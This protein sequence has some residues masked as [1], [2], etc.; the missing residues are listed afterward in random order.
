MPSTA[1]IQRIV[2]VL[3]ALL[4]FAPAVRAQAA[5]QES[6]T[7]SFKVG[8]AERRAIL[9]N[10]PKAGE[11]RPV[12]IILH[13][14]MGS[15]DDMRARSGFDGVAKANGFMAVY[16]EGTAF[17]AIEGRHAWNTGHLLRRQVREAD[18]I[19]Y[20]DGL[21]D[22]LIA[23]HGADPARMFMTGGS[24]G[25]MM[26]FV[27][28][29]TRPERLA[30]AAPVVASMFSFD[31]VPK[32]P[33]PILIINGAKDEEV[34]LAGGLSGNAL[35]RA[36]QATPFKPVREVVDFWVKANRSTS[37]GAVR[38]DGSVTT[39]TYAAGESGAVTESVVDRDG[40]HGWPGAPSRRDGNAPIMAFQ[41]A[42]RVW[43]FFAGKS[44]ATLEPAVK[45]A[46]ATEVIEFPNLVDAARN[47]RVPI[48]V[49]APSTGGPHP[50]IVL[51]HGAGGDWDTHF[52]QAQDL[53]ANGY[54][55]LCLEHVGSNRERLTKGLRPMKNLDAMIRDADEVLAR[56]KDVS[57]AIDQATA[58]NRSHEQLRGR[59]DLAKVGAMG[60]SFGA[61]TT[62][63]VCGMR[64]ALD[65]LEPP[66]APGKGLGPDLRDPRIRC[67][68]ALS[69]QGV[70]EPFFVRDSF[71]TLRV[72]LLGIS[73]T[74]DSQQAGQPA[75]NRK[76]AFALW[77]RG[78]HRF[79]WLE[80]ARHLDF[81]DS[82]GSGARA[83]PSATRAD[84]QPVTRAAALAFFDL[85]LKSRQDAADRLTVERL[86][87]L[88][89]GAI[90]K[91]EVLV[92]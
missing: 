31:V 70:G 7:V 15:A 41:G 72:P 75:E 57:F 83:L 59:L 40:G 23:D 4:A 82:S 74:K 39:T 10:A 81:T 45:A 89:Q 35:V 64:P 14:G 6:E 85:H 8:D 26:T 71:A 25:G 88:L 24:N 90:R 12:V 38:T 91:V 67:G 47:R 29:A 17:G 27:Y 21:I 37:D 58:W 84:A 56:P 52:A 68:V 78:A 50:V 44:R 69:P 20:F 16:A 92:R 30:A 33:L 66:V 76:D 3:L 32:V 36:A 28:A 54:V 18:D 55:V 86:S 65:W 5:P 42:D 77:P 79:V 19:A 80:N 51:S 9:V 11:K 46:R 87:R 1:R 43:Q 63:V 53:A 13:G 61:F 62:M 2:S 48:K 22:R 49:H 60:H 73:G 34:P